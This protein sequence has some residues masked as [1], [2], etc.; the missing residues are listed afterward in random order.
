MDPERFRRPMLKR[1]NPKPRR[2]N[3]G[4]AYHGCLVVTVTKASALY[5]AIDG[6]WAA[7]AE[8]FK[9][10]DGAEN[11]VRWTQCDPGSSKG[12]TADFDSVDGGS[13]PSP[14][15]GHPSSSPWMPRRRWEQA[16]PL[17]WIQ[18]D[19]LVDAP[20]ESA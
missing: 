13:N 20:S 18:P 14:G 4:A 1:H 16:V 19:S 10:N 6:W 15:A 12:R 3:T 5:D 9:V 7:I 17:G 2:H 11:C 8:G